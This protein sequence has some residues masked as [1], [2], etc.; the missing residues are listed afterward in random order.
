MSKRGRSDDDRNRASRDEVPHYEGQVV[1]KGDYDE[2]A[3][4]E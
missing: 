3:D 4:S 1:F 2:D